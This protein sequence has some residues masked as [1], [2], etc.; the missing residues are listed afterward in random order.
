MSYYTAEATVEVQGYTIPKGTNIIM[1]ICAIHCKPDVWV[2]PNRFMPE[3]FMETDTNFFGKHPEFILFGGG[4]RI[5]LGLPLAYMQDGSYGSC[6]TIV[7]LSLEASGRSRERWCGYEGEV[8]D[9]ASERDTTQRLG[10]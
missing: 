4:R 9:C 1:N 5:C 2:D 3:R 6:I 8:W 10:Y 7:S